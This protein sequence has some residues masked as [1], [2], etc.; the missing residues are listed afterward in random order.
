M[1]LLEI[2]VLILAFGAIFTIVAW[3]IWTGSPPTPTSPKVYRSMITILP[4]RLPHVSD[5]RIYELGAGWGGVSRLLAD[6][7]NPMLVVGIELSPLPFTVAWI[8]NLLAPKRNLRFRCVNFFKVELSDA[9][10][11]VCYL[12][13]DALIKLTPK[14]E[15]ELAPEALIV[16]HTFRIPGWQI[17]DTIRAPDLY[18][19]PI[20]LYERSDAVARSSQS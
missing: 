19:T 1:M 8:R 2:I 10:L 11:V 18:R 9:A 12:S 5:G 3:T 14:L 6:Q 20:Y 17:I 4:P 15:D 16:S 13:R 7:F